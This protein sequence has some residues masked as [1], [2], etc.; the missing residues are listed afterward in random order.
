MTM[1]E[2]SH[3]SWSI[4]PTSEVVSEETVTTRAMRMRCN[5]S[6]GFAFCTLRMRPDGGVAWFGNERGIF[7][8]PY[9]RASYLLISPGLIVMDK[10]LV[11]AIM[12]GHIR[13]IQKLA[14]WQ[15]L[16]RARL[17]V[18][19]AQDITTESRGIERAYVCFVAR[20]GSG[21]RVRCWDVHA[22]RSRCPIRTRW[23]TN[24][25]GDVGPDMHGVG[26]MSRFTV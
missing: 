24:D 18:S 13:S 21:C 15:S 8:K 7:C 17:Q 5:G 4:I 23:L 16:K 14:A 2:E 3:S 6:E 26:A 11:L 22:V 9:P 12:D 20:S 19:T 10:V 25:S 1:A